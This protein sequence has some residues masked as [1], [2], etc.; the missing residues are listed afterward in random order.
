MG[1]TMVRA[2]LCGTAAERKKKKSQFGTNFPPPVQKSEKAEALLSAVLQIHCQPV[3]FNIA[4]TLDLEIRL[5][6]FLLFFALQSSALPI[7]N[8][9]DTLTRSLI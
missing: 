4:I 7:G 2:E 3:L 6:G 9:C 5:E 8:W 1:C